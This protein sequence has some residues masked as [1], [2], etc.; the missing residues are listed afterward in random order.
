MRRGLA[1]GLSVALVCALAACGSSGKT[2]APGP[3]TTS[4]PF[5]NAAWDKAGPEPS[6]SAKMVCS[7][8]ARED[9]TTALGIAAKRVTKPTWDAEKHL[10]S[11]D[12]VYPR[13]TIRLVVKEMSSEDETTE[14]FERVQRKYGAVRQL[15]GIGQGATVLRNGD[16]V[17]RKDY[18]TLLV[19]V[20]RI[21]QRMIPAMRRS[22][23]AINIANVIMTCWIGA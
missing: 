4:N 9:I 11:C 10:Y 5:A 1:G 16:I 14:Y 12:Y 20:T 22:D 21:P 13:G 2:A 23:V 17:V 18:K 3:T 6:V 8:E 15:K 19:D 7:A